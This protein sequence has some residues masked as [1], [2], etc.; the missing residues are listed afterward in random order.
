M[1]HA[2]LA[3]GAVVAGAALVAGAW[4]ADDPGGWA[5]LIYT[6]AIIAMFGVSAVYHRVHWQS[7]K[8]EMWMMRADHS[9]IFVFIAGSYAPIAMLA[10]PSAR[11]HRC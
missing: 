4:V 7:F 3:V 2:G 8:A 5:T 11:R 6:V 1:N 9:L 10:M